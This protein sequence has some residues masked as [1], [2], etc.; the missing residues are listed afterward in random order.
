MN[1]QFSEHEE[2]LLRSWDGS[3][4]A[5]ERQTLAEV[6][7]NNPAMRQQSEQYQKIRTMLLR[8]EPDSFGPFFAE[9]IMNMIKQRTQEIDYLIFFFFKKYQVLLVGVLVALLVSN[10][11]LT[12]QL[13]VKG[14]LGLDQGT[15][16]DVY[17]IDLYDNLTK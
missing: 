12:D 17:T 11:L 4:S 6:M 13:T 5:R 3:V 16:E 2:L 7:Q 14:I 8:T 15:T 1:D 9:R 10:M